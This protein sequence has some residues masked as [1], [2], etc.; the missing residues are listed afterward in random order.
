MLYIIN[1]FQYHFWLKLI[2]D[3]I[4]VKFVSLIEN[5]FDKQQFSSSAHLWI[6][7]VPF[8]KI[9]TVVSLYL[10]TVTKLIPYF[11]KN[12]KPFK[13]QKLIFAYNVTMVA[14]NCYAFSRFV[15]FIAT[16]SLADC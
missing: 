3:I 15:Y 7:S 6:S 1:L 9:V 10:L 14:I 4:N 2:S 16:T 8:W 12:R 5:F 11:I 13:L